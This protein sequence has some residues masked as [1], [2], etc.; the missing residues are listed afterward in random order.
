[1]KRVKGSCVEGVRKVSLV[2][3]PT[4]VINGT[5]TAN[6]EESCSVTR[7]MIKTWPVICGIMAIVLLL[8]ATVTFLFCFCRVKSRYN[9][10]LE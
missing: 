3:S 9:R 4:C 1:M 8:V 7:E 2:P 10:L 5:L 6:F